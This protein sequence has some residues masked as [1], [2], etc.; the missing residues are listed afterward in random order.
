MG[1]FTMKEGRKYWHVEF[2][3]VLWVA[4]FV[5]AGRT[6]GLGNM[7]PCFPVHEIFSRVLYNTFLK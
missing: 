7:Q 6:S 4:K 2:I 1:A 5:K 3:Q